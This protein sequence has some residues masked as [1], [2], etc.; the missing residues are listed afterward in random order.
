[1]IIGDAGQRHL[2]LRS[3]A[4]WPTVGRNEADAVRHNWWLYHTYL[5]VSISAIG[6]AE[7]QKLNQ[8]AAG[9]VSFW[10][11]YII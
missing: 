4:P 8:T 5:Y 3:D 9:G 7:N 2:L 10:V 11:F 1:M 6:R